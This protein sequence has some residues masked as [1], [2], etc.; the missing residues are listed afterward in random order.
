MVTI[1]PE[2]QNR[3]RNDGIRK[4]AGLYVPCKILI[5]RLEG[6]GQCLLPARLASWQ[7]LSARSG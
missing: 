5:D 4:R 7:L 1:C 6:E 3:D 2:I